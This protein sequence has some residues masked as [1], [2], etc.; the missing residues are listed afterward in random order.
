MIYRKMEGQNAKLAFF[1]L[2]LVL[3]RRGGRQAGE[4]LGRAGE[5]QGARSS[6]RGRAASSSS[7]GGRAGADAQAAPER[8]R[9][10]A[11]ATA[12]KGDREESVREREGARVGREEGARR[13]FI[14][15]DGR[16][17]GEPGRN[18]RQWPSMAAINAIE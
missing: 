13:A 1:Y 16:G 14:E 3:T 8:Q 11:T 10:R 15:R 6:G 12:S 18:G 5:E 17:E 9:F 4:G 2:E 7:G